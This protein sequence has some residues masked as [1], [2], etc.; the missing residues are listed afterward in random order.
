MKDRKKVLVFLGHED[1]DTLSGALADSFEKGARDNGHEVKRINICDLKFDPILHKGYKEIQELEPDLKRVQEEM[2]W[3]DH[4]AIFYPNWWGTMPAIL[5][6][7][8]DRMFLPRFAFGFRKTGFMKRLRWE[9]LMKGKSA[10]VCITMNY[11]PWIA[12]LLFG[13]NSNE[14]TK[15]ILGFSGFSPIYLVKMGPVEKMP[16]EKIEVLKKRAYQMGKKAK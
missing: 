5:K 1:C 3:A 2:K 8:F 15:N 13:D 14:I 6:G 12:R 16:E 11:K 7:M 10:H 4:F 9:K